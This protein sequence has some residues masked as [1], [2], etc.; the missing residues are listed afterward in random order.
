MPDFMKLRSNIRLNAQA[1]LLCICLGLF[2]GNLNA[3]TAF[4]TRN[5]SVEWKLLNN[6]YNNEGASLSAF[7]FKN[8]GVQSFPENGWKMYFNFGKSVLPDEISGNVK[9]EHINGDIFCLSPLQNF[10]VLKPGDSCVLPILSE[11]EFLTSTSVPSGLYLVWDNNPV[12][13]ITITSYKAQPF[14]DE[15]SGFVTA[16]STYTKN[17]GLT[18]LP[19]NA[20]CKILPSPVSYRETADI[21][22]LDKSVIIKS[23]NRFEAEGTYL[24]GILSERLGTE[25]TGM[26]GTKSAGTIRLEYSPM[27]DE[28]YT[29]DVTA[30][31]IRITAGSASGIFYGIQSL[32]ALFPVS[33]WKTAQKSIS[34]PGIQVQD[35]PRFGFRSL[36]IDIAR[37]FQS[38]EQL[39][40]IIDLMALYKLNVLHLHFSDDEGWRIQIPSLPELTEVGSRRGHTL[41]S[42]EFLP[43]SYAS[44]PEPGIGSGSGYYSRDEFIALLKYATERHIKVIPEIE[45]PGHSRAAIKS[46][47][48]RYEKFMAKGDKIKAEEFLLRDMQDKSMYSSAQLWTDN[49]MCV[50]MPSVYHFIGVVVD[51]LLKM[52][53]EAGAPIETIHM[54]GDEVPEGVWQKSPLCAELIA[55][56]GEVRNV[57][58]LWKYYFIRVDS[59]LKLRKLSVSGWE[60]VAMHKTMLDGSKH[61]I[62]SPYFV[63]KDI[64]VNVWNN[65]IGWGSEDLPYRLANAGYKVV[66]SCVSNQYF[67][68]AYERHPEEPGYYWG[69]FVDTDKPY[70]FI[71]YDYYRNTREAVDGSPVGPELFV[72]KDRL[73][74]YG[75]TNIL[76][77]QGLLWAENLRSSERQEYML[78]PKMLA[79][80][81]RAWAKD[82][83]WVRAE[84]QVKA[85]KLYDQ[86]WNLFVNQLGCRELPKLDYFHGGFNYR[87]P[88]VGLKIE[89]GAVKA[90][91]QIPGIEIRYSMDGKEPTSKS[92]LYLIPLKAGGNY[93]FAAFNSLGRRGRI[94]EI[95]L[96]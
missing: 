69:G 76:G 85:G 50:A 56:G 90:N 24:K 83:D 18:T 77:I 10:S 33:A 88:A 11:G 86:S 81:E 37:N 28:C 62:P 96:K 57:D 95:S 25:I 46:M 79:L 52:Y 53:Q 44:G 58:D 14:W 55:K 3:Q 32:Q 54:G 38:R 16:L 48:A 35:Q 12:K 82:P 39:M 60:E 6:H 2:A 91:C 30:T 7:I 92:P 19:V 64:R 36:H 84:D 70:Y 13:G 49:V 23:D 1:I 63:G 93:R 15:N 17:S 78:L 20:I 66:L 73:T 4:D 9:I 89:D 80:A 5:L 34:V 42:R 67:D 21:F 59:L 61:F 47:D 43:P 31:E 65:G 8:S 94:S 74:E 22:K 27:A 26:A 40:K 72:G 45:T 71:P 29:L 41:D 75:K 87:I 68:L 51:D